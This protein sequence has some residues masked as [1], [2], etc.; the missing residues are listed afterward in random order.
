MVYEERIFL[1]GATGNIGQPLVRRLLSDPKVAVTLYARSPAKVQELYG[2]DHPQGKLQIVQG[3][4]VNRTAFEQSISGHARLFLLIQPTDLNAYLATPRAFAEK[5][6]NAGVQQVLMLGG[7]AASMPYRSVMFNSVAVQ[8]E[9]SLLSI[10][11]RKALVTL[12]PAFFMSNQLATDVLTI[13]SACKVISTRDPNETQAW[14]SPNDIADVAANILLDTVEKHGDA[15]YEMIG[16]PRTPTEHAAILSKVLGKNITY[17]RASEQ[18]SY[19]MMTKQAGMSHLHAYMS[20][21]LMTNAFSNV[22]ATPGLSILL[23]RPPQ[24]LEQ[25]IKQNKSAFL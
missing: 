6:Y 9:K 17:E 13:K 11:N 4:Y 23:G 25:W 14:I 22:K 24:T 2:N 12:R 18:Q 15:V 7:V 3:D 8:V 19:D 5:A 1:I 21:Q 20:L 16:D 10:P